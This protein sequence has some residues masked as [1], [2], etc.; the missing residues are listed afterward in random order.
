MGTC[1]CLMM[2]RSGLGTSM[3]FSMI[4]STVRSLNMARTT[5]FRLRAQ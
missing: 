4:F 3:R 1:I 5:F 2:I